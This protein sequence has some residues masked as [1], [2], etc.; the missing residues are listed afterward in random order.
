MSTAKPN[1]AV[2]IMVA[3]N[4]AAAIGLLAAWPWQSG[5]R[6]M[7]FLIV[8]MVHVV[9]T[10]GLWRMKNWA[11]ILMICYALFQFAGLSIATVVT[12]ALVQEDGLTPGAR[13]ELVLA[14]VV[15][16]LLLW[17]AIYLLRP[18]GQALFLRH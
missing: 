9:L 8:G 18:A 10:V 4:A 5:L 3:A 13:L 11:R 16:P 1:L 15:L 2:W 7:L 6:G 12:L 17:A 14:G